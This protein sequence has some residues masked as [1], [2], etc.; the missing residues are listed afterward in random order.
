MFVCS[1]TVSTTDKTSSG[2]MVVMLCAD[3][4]TQPLVTI[5]VRRGV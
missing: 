1:R 4:R 5:D 2:M 3:V